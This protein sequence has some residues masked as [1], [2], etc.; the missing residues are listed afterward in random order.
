[1]LEQFCVSQDE[2]HALQA[3][4]DEY[5]EYCALMPDLRYTNIIQRWHGHALEYPRLYRMA[6]DIFSIPAMS[7]EC[8]RVFSSAKPLITDC[9]NRLKDDIIEASEYLKSW[10]AAGIAK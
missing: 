3:P 1:M 6:C 5:T 2:N 8:E 9:R 4:P 10:E 7:A